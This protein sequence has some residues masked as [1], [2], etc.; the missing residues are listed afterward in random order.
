MV[1]TLVRALGAAY[2]LGVSAIAVAKPVTPSVIMDFQALTQPVIAANGTTLAY[3]AQP[4]RGEPVG[5]LQRIGGN[6]FR[7]VGG[8]EPQ[9]SADGQ[10]GLFRLGE[11]LLEQENRLAHIPAPTTAV[12][13][14]VD[15]Q[16]GQQVRFEHVKQAWFTADSNYLLLLHG[17]SSEAAPNAPKEGTTLTIRDLRSGAT[18]VI[19]QVWQVA[20]AENAAEIAYSVRTKDG[21]GNGIYWLN[22]DFSHEVV[23][24][25]AG[26]IS[27]DL[28]ISDDGQL[29]AFSWGNEAQPKRQ[30]AHQLGLYQRNSKVRWH[31]QNHA[32]FLV[33]GFSQLTFSSDKQRLFVGRQAQR[34]QLQPVGQYPNA[35]ALTNLQQLQAKANVVLWHGD[36]ASIKPHEQQ[37]FAD[38]YSRQYL[39]VWHLDN[40]NFVQL[41]D[42]YLEGVDL[43]QSNQYGLGYSDLLYRKIASWAGEYR[44][45]Y[46]INLRTG[47]RQLLVT[48]GLKD[49]VPTLSPDGRAVA[50]YVRGELYWHDVAS[51][52]TT[53]LGGGFA[54][55]EYDL[56]GA[57]PS[58]G[59]GPWLS[60][61][62]GVLV[63]DK[64]DVHQLQAGTLRKLTEG[65]L[66]RT[67]Y[68]VIEEDNAPLDPNLP[69][70]L[71][72]VNELNRAEGLHYVQ[73]ASGELTTWQHGEQRI[74]FVAKAQ[75]AQNRLYSQ[76]SYH[77]Y[78]DLYLAPTP[79]AALTQVTFLGNQLT[80]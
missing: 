60:G 43:P 14:L 46:L 57:V 12:R 47:A 18:R 40:N 5:H 25:E 80:G 51:G 42:P 48:Q 8:H 9:I 39:A 36:D 74:R 69:I 66:L 7:V 24:E 45:W 33:T 29:L 26:F 65:R 4:D 56:A 68:R 78:P 54:Q 75:Q 10:Y 2:L 44:D 37:R 73:L 49:D 55:E 63:Y 11:R 32:D 34:P 50:W 52:L 61:N 64:Y 67:R 41:A 38:E 79:E 21:S 77:R 22:A 72:S 71:H 28:T 3:V 15:S 35:A 23:H 13:L 27:G 76:E 19:G 58:Y 30:R 59:F 1:T 31:S 16:T 62:N 6:L 20:L 53:K 70:P 17:H